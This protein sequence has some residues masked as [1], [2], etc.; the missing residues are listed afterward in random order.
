MV[1]GCVGGAGRRVRSLR[2]SAGIVRIIEAT[3][4][5]KSDFG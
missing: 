4:P 2:Q 3:W 1:I 5:G